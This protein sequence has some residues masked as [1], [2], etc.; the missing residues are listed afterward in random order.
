MINEMINKLNPMQKQAVLTTEGPLLLL[1]GAGSGKTRV[2]THRIAYLISKGVRPFNILAI[3][4]TNKAAKEM[5]ERAAALCDEGS[6]VWVSTFHSTC[7]RILRREIDKLGYTN[8][9]TIFDSDDSQRLMKN[10]YKAYNINDKVYPVKSVLAEISRQ[11]DNMV[12]PKDYMIEKENDFRMKRVAELYGLYQDQL[13]ENNA[14]DFDD[15]IF[16]TVTLFENNPDVLEKYQERFRY[17]MVDEYQDT[18]AS[19]YRLI[20]LLAQKYGNLCAVGDD[21]QSI[22]GWRGADIRNI[23]NFE[24]DFKNTKV[25][26][27]EQNYRSSENILNSANAVI[28]NNFARKAKSLWTDKGSGEKITLYRASTDREEAMFAAS[29][30]VE[31]HDNGQSY[32][33]FAILYRNNA[34]SRVFEESL[35]KAAIPYR[36]LGGT[37][38]YDRK[39]IR[40]ILA[41]LKFIINPNDTISFSRIVNVP[42]RG[43]GDATVEK[44]LNYCMDSGQPLYTVLGMPEM[45]PDI[46]TKAKALYGFYEFIDQFVGKTEG[47]PV[48]DIIKNILSKSGYH[49]E[50]AAEGSEEAE[51]RLENLEELVSKAAEFVESPSGQTGL[52][53]FLEEVA[54]VADV[55]G[56]DEN[57]DAV[58]LMTL[59][60]SK[61]LEFDTVFI[62]ACENGIFPGY[63]AMQADTPSEM[64]EERRLCYV[65][66]TRAKRKLYMTCAKSRMQFGETH[67]NSPSDFLKELPKELTEVQ[68][69][70]A[71]T[72]KAGTAIPK[73]VK[74]QYVPQTRYVTK[75]ANPYSIPAPKNFEIDFEVGDKVKHMKF[76]IGTV[77]AIQPAGADFEVTA[78]FNA[79]TKKLMAKLAK[80]RKC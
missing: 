13:K 47:V 74:Q 37:R 23:L 61:G 70:A 49:S 68:D 65:G 24:D 31:G 19:Q 39:E 4:F 56:L 62:A 69:P 26:K 18:N 78:E 51:G 27:L 75:G 20:K 58:V 16:K 73:P 46:K 35:V 64:E 50:L 15:L 52:E 77:I 32:N 8:Q 9:F 42:K 6:D 72:A 36:L 55:D 43:I 1:A 60:S 66:I 30:I 63:R 29:K 25:I 33:D 44:L 38:F 7:V 3:T 79:G 40:D 2:L 76:G 17:I 22:Y 14:L 12:T 28:K 5:K 41:Y 53:G 71:S 54:L 57:E 10:I 80:L 34:I 48:A 67:Y 45:I 11:K 21:D 59:H